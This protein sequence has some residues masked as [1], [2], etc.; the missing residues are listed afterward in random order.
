MQ[1]EFRPTSVV[2]VKTE[3]ARRLMHVGLSIRFWANPNCG[4]SDRSQIG[5]GMSG[6]LSGTSLSARLH[7]P[8]SGHATDRLSRRIRDRQKR[9]TARIK[10]LG[11]CEARQRQAHPWSFGSNSAHGAREEKSRLKA[12][13]RK[14]VT[15]DL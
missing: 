15:I 3:Y 2:E 1:T 14:F 6:S 12:G 5:R 4:H 11:R 8:G 9:E 13:C 10:A 7:R